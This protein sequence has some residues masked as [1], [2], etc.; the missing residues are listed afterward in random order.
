MLVRISLIIALIAGLAAVGLNFTLVKEKITTLQT[1]LKEQTDRAVKA[2][3]ERDDT[4]RTLKKT[5]TELAQTKETLKTTTEQRDTAIAEASKAT[6]RA[7][8]LD[9]ELT[10]TRGERDTAQQEL[11]RFKAAGMT[12]EEIV[13][14]NKTIKGL[15]DSLAGSQE[16]N[17]I[18]GLNI[19]K[20]N[21]ELNKFLD[22]DRPVPLP[23]GLKGKVLVCD[24]KWQF[25][26]LNVGEN[27]KVLERAELLVNRDGKLVAKVRVSSVQKDRCVANV[28][29]G[30]Q[31]GEILEGDQVIP[32]HPES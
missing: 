16:E 7:T 4:K 12:P 24:P 11:A 8:K 27:Q 23:A 30:W 25:V 6:D 10:K 26:V 14:A 3:K 5:E 21:N 20:L 18:L 22:P 9:A 28:I 15:Q 19:A 17:K 32:A 31:L 2:E 1:H 29:P 13:N